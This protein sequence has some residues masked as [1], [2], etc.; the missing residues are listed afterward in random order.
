MKS[1]ILKVGI[2]TLALVAFNSSKAQDLKRPNPEKA[3][4][5][6]DANN[7]GLLTLEEFKSKTRKRDV[8]AEKLEKN[9]SRLDSDSNGSV[10]L[11][12]FKAGAAKRAENRGKR[13]RR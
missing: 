11:E 7:D 5:K 13:R 8:S 2:L 4:S 9:F 3:F 1:P 6:I 12:E 10:S